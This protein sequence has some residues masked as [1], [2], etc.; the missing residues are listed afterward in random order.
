[1][2][3]IVHILAFLLSH[4]LFKGLVNI[5]LTMWTHAVLIKFLLK[6]HFL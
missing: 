4:I 1:M 3:I 5:L 2:L 6:F